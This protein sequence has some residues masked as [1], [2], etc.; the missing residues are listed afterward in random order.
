[1]SSLD[2]FQLKREEFYF[3]IFPLV[4]L[5]SELTIPEMRANPPVVAHFWWVFF[6][7]HVKTSELTISGPEGNPL[8]DRPWSD[9]L[10]G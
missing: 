6:C 7:A 5:K 2:Y 9:F 1:M 3:S 4:G 8:G 10:K